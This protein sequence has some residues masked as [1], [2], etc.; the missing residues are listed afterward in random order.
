MEEKENVMVEKSLD[1]GARCIG[2]QRYLK[3]DKNEN[4]IS[5]QVGRS[6]TGIGANISEANYAQSN[7]DFISKMHIA[8]K[9]TAETEYWIRLLKKTDLIDEKMEKSLIEDCLELKRL[10][11]ATINT[12]KGKAEEK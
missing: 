1:F 10:L 3:Y 6:G 9:E 12:A 11:I 2:L 4:V 7:L 8:L 5:N